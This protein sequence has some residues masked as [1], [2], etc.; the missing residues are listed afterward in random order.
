MSRVFAQELDLTSVSEKF[1]ARFWSKVDVRSPEECWEWQA[2]RTGHGYGQFCLRKGMP[3]TASRIVM[4]LTIGRPLA[5]GEVACHACDN[6]PCVNPAHIFPGTQ[7]DNAKDCV[8]KGRRN[9]AF[10]ERNGAKLTEADVREILSAPA[11]YGITE[12]L[13]RQYGVAG[14]TIRAIRA[15][16]KWKHIDEVAS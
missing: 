7:S 8:R 5:Q 9:A 12:Q 6:P 10:G 13:G 15:R 14:N 1:L 11:R 16:R 3:M 2:S 4:G